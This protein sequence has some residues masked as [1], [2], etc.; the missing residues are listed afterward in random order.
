MA[1][2]LSRPQWVNTVS[3]SRIH[4]DETLLEIQTFSP[5][6]P[7]KKKMLW[8]YHVRYADNV[9]VSDSVTWFPSV[10]RIRLTRATALI[11]GKCHPTSCQ[12]P[13]ISAGFL[14][15][16]GGGKLALSITRP[17]SLRYVSVVINWNPRN[18]QW[19]QNCYHGECWFLVLLNLEMASQWR[20]KYR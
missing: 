16:L 2:I 4:F 15:H 9:Q 1:S 13:V 20:I 6:P 12:F 18:H 3:Q 19:P 8:N 10:F 11:P 14:R 5:P 17:L 7:P